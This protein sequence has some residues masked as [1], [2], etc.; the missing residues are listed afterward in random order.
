MCLDTIK[1]EE[2]A[3]FSIN[4]IKDDPDNTQIIY[5]SANDKALNTSNYL[6]L[7]HSAG[8]ITLQNE[9]NGVYKLS[10]LNID[11]YDEPC[12][13]ELF[14]ESQIVQTSNAIY[15]IISFFYDFEKKL[16]FT[17]NITFSY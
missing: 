1:S 4:V 15:K 12:T 2:I 16:C 9:V 14:V 5:K 8:K 3:G 7:C 13:L 10:G 17:S 11:F 6:A